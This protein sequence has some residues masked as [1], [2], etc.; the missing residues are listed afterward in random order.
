MRLNEKRGALFRDL[1]FK[2]CD[3]EE[4]NR[5]AAEAARSHEGH[6]EFKKKKDEQLDSLKGRE[7]LNN[8]VVQV[9]QM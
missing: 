8:H 1:C 4:K 6:S 9:A 3:S 2:N 7:A 5:V